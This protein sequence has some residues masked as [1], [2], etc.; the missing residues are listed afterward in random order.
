[1]PDASRVAATSRRASRTEAGSLGKY[2][3]A[4]LGEIVMLPTPLTARRIRPS[5]VD[6]HLNV[7]IDLKHLV[8]PGHLE[9][10]F[11]NAR[12]HDETQLG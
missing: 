1:M 8:D 5:A 3:D 6:R 4:W 11:D 7:W 9:Q 2:S 12:L 10:S